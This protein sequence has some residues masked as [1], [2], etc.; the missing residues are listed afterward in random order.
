MT[1]TVRRIF[2]PNP[3]SDLDPFRDVVVALKFRQ[4]GAVL[5]D[6]P[7]SRHGLMKPEGRRTIMGGG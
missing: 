3:H 2:A 4:F 7:P 1:Q 6:V 5:A